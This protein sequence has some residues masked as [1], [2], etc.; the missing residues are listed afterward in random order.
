MFSIVIPL[1]NKE[2]SIQN[3]LQSVLR[4]SFTDFEV[5]VVDD[6]S[7]DLSCERVEELNDVRVRIFKKKNG[8]VC[9]ARNKGIEE[10]KYDYIAFLDADDYWEPNY[11]KE[12]LH[13][14]TDFPDAA[15]WGCA[16][17]FKFGDKK[18]QIDHVLPINY[19]DFV[20]N[21]F[22]LR[23]KTDLFHTSAVVIKK[24]AFAEVGMFDIRIKYGEDLDMWY[25]IIN[26]FPV[27][28]F[29]KTLAYY[30]QEA[31][32]R[33]LNKS[34]KLAEYLP[35][36]ID[37]YNTDAR[38]SD[39]F[40]RY[41]NNWAAVK[42]MYYYF[43][44][45]TERSDARMAIKKLDFSKIHRKYTLFFKTPFYFGYAVYKLISIKKWTYKNL[46]IYKSK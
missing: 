23:R 17:G 3:T 12:Q 39:I 37:K 42:I 30:Q 1:Y 14:I 46:A 25:R 2:E 45:K 6:G 4:Q 31:E 33:A 22:G 15:L 7:T 36:Y 26:H 5:I 13:L 41:I 24:E 27:V 40:L 44:S 9:S 16:F 32:N 38:N 34:I 20:S 21:Y 35:F 29:N 18:Q 10:S 28:F 8:G 19:R 11:L 43:N